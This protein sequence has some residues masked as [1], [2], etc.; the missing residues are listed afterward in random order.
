MPAT[1]LRSRIFITIFG[2]VLVVTIASIYIHSLFLRQER[3]RFIDQQVRETATALVDSELGDLRKINFDQ[4]ER[5]ISQELG[6]TRVGKFF[7]IRNERG[8]VLYQSSATLKLLI[9]NIPKSPQWVDIYTKGKFLRVLNLKLPSIND[10]TLQVGLVVD[11]NILSPDYIS[12]RSL[13]LLACVLVLG[14]L[15]SLILTS[16]VLK[17]MGRLER[18]IWEIADQSK[19][20]P[21][22][23]N[24]P[25]NLLENAN[26]K[27]RD[28]FE[29]TVAGLNLLIDKVNRN[30]RLSRLWAY[31]MAHELKT[32]LAI[33]TLEIEKVHRRNEA[34]GL[35]LES[36]ID[37]ATSE[38]S[39]IAETISS[40]LNWAELEN[41][42][43]QRHLFINKLATVTKNLANRLEVAYGKRLSLDLQADPTVVANPH[44]LEQLITNIVTNALHYSEASTPVTIRI[45]DRT[46]TVI[47]EGK[48]IAKEVLERLGEPFNRGDLGSQPRKGNGLG[49]AWV[50]SI[51]RLYDWSLV[52]ES[53][54]TG[55]TIQVTFPPEED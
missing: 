52:I 23:P 47:D 34:S 30:Y 50:K 9:P 49:L 45:V 39:R 40:F 5:I 10:R 33:L 32:P 46:L 25:A 42:N 51:C 54:A 41:S 8:D 18:F 20:Q 19:S 22:I 27:S 28:E 3:L 21:Q 6:E 2:V 44:H 7:V 29:R 17:P 38:A 43:Q 24:V 15:A 14:F 37:S 12:K 26:K 55:T 11:Q 31:Q 53:H 1:G 48:G 36:N 13:L 4:A 16:L 35:G